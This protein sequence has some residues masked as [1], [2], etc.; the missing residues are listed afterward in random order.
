M[1]HTIALSN[2][3]RAEKWMKCLLCDKCCRDN[4]S[5]AGS[6]GP[7][8]PT[9]SKDHFKNLRYYDS[10]KDQVRQDKLG[11]HTELARFHIY[12]LTTSK[13]LDVMQRAMDEEVKVEQVSCDGQD[14]A[15]EHLSNPAVPVLDE[16]PMPYDL[17]VHVDDVVHSQQSVS[18]RFS[19]GRTFYELTNALIDSRIDPL[20][21]HFLKLDVVS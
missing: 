19:C 20:Q 7:L 18:R 3:A 9:G 16:C 2:G 21:A 12:I 10:Y 11:Y 1:G 15:A 14:G 13:L 17:E 5:H 4:W 8:N 6:P